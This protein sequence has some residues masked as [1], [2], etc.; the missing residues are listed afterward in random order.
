MA[1]SGHENESSLKQYAVKCPESKK[2]EMFKTLNTLL[3]PN[4][5]ASAATETVTTNNLTND[6][7]AYL[8]S[9]FYFS[10]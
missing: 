4:P 10:S 7:V 8:L 6:I 3:D 2:K 5:K 9:C 1:L